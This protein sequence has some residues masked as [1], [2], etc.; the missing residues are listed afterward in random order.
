MSRILLVDDQPDVLSFGSRVLKRLGYDVLTA[1]DSRKALEILKSTMVDLLITDIMM[2]EMTGTELLTEA[3]KLRPNLA[4]VVITGHA[5]IDLAIKALRAGAHDFVTKPFGIPDLKAAVDHALAQSH[6]AQEAVRL[7]A[8]GPLFEISNRRQADLGESEWAEDVLKIVVAHLSAKGGAFF[9]AEDGQEGMTIKATVG[10]LSSDGAD[11][12]EP[13]KLFTCPRQVSVMA[14]AD[15]PVGMRGLFQ[16]CGTALVAPLCAPNRFLGELV[17]FKAADQVSFQQSDLETISV[18]ATQVATFW[19]NHR[20]VTQLERWNRELEDRVKERTRSLRAAQEKLIRAERLA[21]VGQL[22]ASVAHELRNPLGVISNSVYYLGTKLGGADAKI[23]KH[24]GIISR[25]VGMANAI[26]ADLMNF[27]RVAQIETAPFAPNE[28]VAATLD[29]AM[30]PENVR[31]NVD[32]AAGLPPVYVDADKAQQVFLN[33]VNNAV[34]A[35]SKGGE[36]SVRTGIANGHVMFTF[37]DSGVGIPAENLERIFEPLFTTKAKGI[38]LGLSV[39][40]LLVEAHEG[41]ITV[42]SRPDKGASFVVRLPHRRQQEES[43]A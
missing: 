13:V 11:E 16:D 41:Q 37:Q 40:K 15:L 7:Q 17:V 5:D 4:A 19:E 29:R 35:M 34:Q 33:L 27:V 20:L 6:K 31:V 38:G 43:A 22:G 32:L 1:S 26:I 2:P 3:H 23:T 18:L 21:T 36:L 10:A 24:L 39:A 8:L 28:L 42:S 30:I 25:E 9:L 12:R 14:V